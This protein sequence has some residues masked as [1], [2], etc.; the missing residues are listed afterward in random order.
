MRYEQ[1]HS[2]LVDDV[3]F[4]VL[5]LGSCRYSVDLAE[6][7]RAGGHNSDVHSSLLRDFAV[8]MRGGTVVLSLRPSLARESRHDLDRR[9]VL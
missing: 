3:G 4:R 6:C 5:S 7:R 2:C 9:S 1:N 8:H